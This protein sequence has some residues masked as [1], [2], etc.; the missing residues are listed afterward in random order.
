[1]FGPAEERA[2][3]AR[4]AGAPATGSQAPGV[5]TLRVPSPEGSRAQHPPAQGL[6]PRE[7]TSPWRRWHPPFWPS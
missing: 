3:G 2:W 5:S 7:R 4:P 6:T 1:L